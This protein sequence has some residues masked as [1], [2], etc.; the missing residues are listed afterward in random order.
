VALLL[1]GPEWAAIGDRAR[2]HVRRRFTL[3][4]MKRQTLEVYDRLLGSDLAVRFSVANTTRMG[5][6]EA[7][8]PA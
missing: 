3:E 2:L 4:A 7:R 1:P 8:G 5:A 6:A